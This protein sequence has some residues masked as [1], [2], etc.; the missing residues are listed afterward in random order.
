MKK[1]IIC[2]IAIL[3]LQTAF[4]QQK[5]KRIWLSGQARNVLFFDQFRSAGDTVSPA[6][7]NSGHT[8]V[9][10]AANIQPNKNTFIH[11]MVRVRNDYG[12]FW[13]G[14][15]TFDVRQLYLKG[16]IANSVRYQVGDINYKMTPYTL[17]N[18]EHDLDYAMLDYTDIYQEILDYDLFY[19]FQNSWR[20]QGAALDFGLEFK[21]YISEIQ[22]NGFI[23]RQNPSN[24]STLNE[25]LYGGGNVTLVQSK[26]LSVGA[27]YINM[28]D[29][30]GTAT[31]SNAL[32]NPVMTA[33]YDL[34]YENDDLLVGLMGELGN[35]SMSIRNDTNAPV[36]EDYFL[37]LGARANY[38][39]LGLEFK[40]RY[41]N[42]GPQFF[43][44]GAQTRRLDYNAIP[45]S[46]SRYG[47]ERLVRSIGLLDLL[48]DG[49][50]YNT[51]L[52]TGL[53]AYNPAY[54]NV[55]PYGEA[56]PNRQ[57]FVFDLSQKDKKKR[58]DINFNGGMLSEVVGQGTAELKSFMYGRALAN[59]YVNQFIGGWDKQIKFS[60]S[61]WTE[62]TER[63]SSFEFEKVNLQN[64]SI[65]VAVDLEFIKNGFLMAS[66]RNLQSVGNE[67]LAERDQYQQIN[68]Y[69]RFDIN[70]SESLVIFGAR[71]DF[72]K[73]SSLS[74]L[75]ND[76]QAD[77]RDN[78]Q[79]S[80]GMNSVAVLYNLK[81]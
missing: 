72:S 10:L 35:S 1:L 24:F 61:V 46:Y 67:Y 17:R 14:G 7:E 62:Q 18:P 38:K 16:I 66:Y 20:Q 52:N 9:D 73:K 15:V 32:V 57:G 6:R 49:T 12:G 22:F 58:W 51:T 64:N 28:F 81:F 3:A 53:G 65:D 2:I 68:N 69:R 54:G 76:Y 11:G 25:R 45:L 60:A 34:K 23:S 31:D 80:N 21:K 63:N 43:S 36:V 40:V 70:M 27:N 39:P 30:L 47:N 50:I 33:T 41:K 71:Y 29:L 78:T 56:T 77:H 74:I 37:D 5:G 44:P 26:Y 55:M 79:P 19:D 8:L 75:W 13:S 42:V 59:L 48:R 4:A